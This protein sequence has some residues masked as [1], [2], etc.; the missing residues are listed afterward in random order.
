[1]IK[2]YEQR[3]REA[4]A[5]SDARLWPDPLRDESGRK[6]G[7]VKLLAIRA[8]GPAMTI[9][10]V[11]ETDYESMRREI[12]RA[13]RKARLA[14]KTCEDCGHAPATREIPSV[15]RKVFLCARCAAPSR[16][17]R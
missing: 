11:R 13:W 7:I 14:G 1:M 5:H 17:N 2:A 16:E 4:A 10:Q 12:D 15:D 8:R 9:M 3:I 6:T